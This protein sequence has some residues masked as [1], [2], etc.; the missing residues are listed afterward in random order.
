[1]IQRLLLATLL[2]YL[3]VAPLSTA[4]SAEPEEGGDC[5]FR[6]CAIVGDGAIVVGDVETTPGGRIA[7]NEPDPTHQWRLVNPCLTEDPVFGGCTAQPPCPEPPDRTVVRFLVQYRLIASGPA[8]SWTD[9]GI[10]CVDITD[11]EPVVTPAMVQAEFER[12]PLPLGEISLQPSD[13]VVLVNVGAIFYTTQDA[14]ASYDVVILGQAVHIDAFI[15]DYAWTVGDGSPDVHGRG[16]PYPDK[17]TLHVYEAPGGV[18]VT[19]TL[20]WD[21]TFTVD[22]GPVTPVLDTTTTL[23]PPSALTIV[24]A[25]S[26]LVDAFD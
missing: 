18:E 24:E 15:T 25:Q 10:D 11:I 3:L 19:L 14:T 23:S 7:L 6:V 8:A 21:A 13:G 20:T 9:D 1:M 22:D 26:I 16:S 12:L 2:M 4:A 17:S 5:R